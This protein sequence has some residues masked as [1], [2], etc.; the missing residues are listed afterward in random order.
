MHLRHLALLIALSAP[1]LAAAAS[2]GD[3]AAPEGVDEAE[4][5]V[6]DLGEVV[7]MGQGMSFEQELTLRMV[8]QGLET[9]RSTRDADKDVMVCWFEEPVGTHHKHLACA[10]NGDLWA[11]RPDAGRGLL[12]RPFGDAGYGTIW[13]TTRPVRRGEILRILDSMPGSSEFDQEFLALAMMGE[14]PPRDIPDDEELDRFTAAYRAVTALDAEAAGDDALEAAIT[15]QGLTLE[16][17]NR[18]I[19]LLDRYQSLM[20]QVAIRLNEDA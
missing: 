19:D 8:R 9:P 18:I 5:D 14:R 10:R 6:L 12:A 1:S 7:A 17:Y 20:N 3:E 15:D 4:V 2:S 11:L 16:R 13:R